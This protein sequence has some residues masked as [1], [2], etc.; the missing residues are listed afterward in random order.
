MNRFFKISEQD[1][2]YLIKCRAKLEALEAGG[3]D[4]WNYYDEAQDEYLEDYFSY[5]DPEFF[6]DNILTFDMLADEEINKFEEV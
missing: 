6:N 4:N 1:L 2:I 3:V 5:C